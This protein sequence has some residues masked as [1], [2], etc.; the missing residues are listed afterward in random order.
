MRRL[1]EIKNG[2]LWFLVPLVVLLFSNA[3]INKH[4]HRWHGMLIEH[5]HP[6]K[7]PISGHQHSHSEAEFILFDLLSPGKID[8]QIAHQPTI[9]ATFTDTAFSFAYIV[10]SISSYLLAYSRLR[11]PPTR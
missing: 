1:R 4:H 7:L 2:L 5:A 10:P 8:D 11:A 6:F 3:A 9:E